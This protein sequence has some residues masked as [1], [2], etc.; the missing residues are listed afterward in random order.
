MAESNTVS[1]FVG[2][3]L[4]TMVLAPFGILLMIRATNDKGIFN[5]DAI[6]QPVTNFFNKLFKLNKNKS[7]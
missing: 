2:G 6:L 1:P 3:W 4:A 7:S 5:I